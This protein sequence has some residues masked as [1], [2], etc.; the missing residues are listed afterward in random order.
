ML[1]ENVN[2]VS[3]ALLSG[4]V[5]RGVP[6]LLSP[7]VTTKQQTDKEQQP[8]VSKIRRFTSLPF[9]TF[10]KEIMPSI[11]PKIINLQ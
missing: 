10:Q 4:L 9:E 7:V 3:V 5:K 8:P 6:I 11:D 2:D 1:E